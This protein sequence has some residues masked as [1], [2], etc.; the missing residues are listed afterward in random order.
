MINN[1]NK[2]DMGF[3]ILLTAQKRELVQVVD[4]VL[5]GLEYLV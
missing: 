3:N 1:K 4:V 5:I 2:L